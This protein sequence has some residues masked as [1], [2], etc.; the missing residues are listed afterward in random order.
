MKKCSVSRGCWEEEVCSYGEVGYKYKWCKI[1]AWHVS[2]DF[3]FVLGSS[4]MEIQS[5]VVSLCSWVYL[6]RFF[7]FTLLVRFFMNL[8]NK[9]DGCVCVC[10]LLLFCFLFRATRH[11]ALPN[12]LFGCLSSCGYDFVFSVTNNRVYFFPLV[13]AHLVWTSSS[14]EK[15]AT[16][17]V[18]V[19]CFYLYFSR[20]M[21]SIVLRVLLFRAFI[22][23][24]KKISIVFV[25]FEPMTGLSVC[26]ACCW[27]LPDS[28]QWAWNRV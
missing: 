26:W 22:V 28:F 1:A 12:S 25:S 13:S 5:F 7:G 16:H 20:S 6:V 27:A 23:F 24:G 14:T 10:L 15:G 3:L 19:L 9:Y 2:F 8:D 17:S 18:C 4:F 11:E 21:R